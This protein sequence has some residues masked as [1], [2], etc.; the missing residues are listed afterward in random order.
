[1]AHGV[2]RVESVEF[3]EKSIAVGVVSAYFVVHRVKRIVIAAFAVFGFMIYRAV[4]FPGCN[5]HLARVIIP[6]KIGCVVLRV[7]EAEFHSAVNR[8]RF[9]RVGIVSDFQNIYFAV[10]AERYKAGKFR[11]KAVFSAF[12]NG[13]IKSV[14]ALIVVERRSGR[15]KSRRKYGLFIGDVIISAAVVGGGGVI[16]IA[17]DSSQFCVAVKGISARSV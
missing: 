9:R 7:P 3:A 5:F 8:E 11:V 2:G 12:K 10:V 15:Q 13:V 6:L 17:R 14:A 1:M 4:F 16:A